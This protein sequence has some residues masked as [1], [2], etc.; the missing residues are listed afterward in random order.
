M[1]NYTRLITFL[2]TIPDVSGT[3]GTSQDVA[4]FQCIFSPSGHIGA[5][6]A[7][8]SEPHFTESVSA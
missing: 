3:A 1:E 2:A 8:E 4:I 7:P 6:N 5:D